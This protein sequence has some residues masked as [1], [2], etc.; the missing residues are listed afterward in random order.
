VQ[1]RKRRGRERGQKGKE[2]DEYRS[3]LRPLYIS[4]YSSL[5]FPFCPL[6]PFLLFLPPTGTGTQQQEH[7]NRKEQQTVTVTATGTDAHVPYQQR[8]NP[9]KG[10]TERKKSVN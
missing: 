2:R 4:F 7:N 9:T 5:S 10:E 8:Q 1:E 6:S 3:G